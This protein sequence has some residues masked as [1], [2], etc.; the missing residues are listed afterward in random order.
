[1]G[2]TLTVELGLTPYLPLTELFDTNRQPIWDIFKQIQ[3]GSIIQIVRPQWDLR[4]VA[5]TYLDISHLG[6]A[7][8]QDD[9]ILFREASL[10]Q[11]KVADTPLVSYLQSLLNQPT[12]KGIN[13]QKFM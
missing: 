2:D 4:A 12:I 10:R 5:G 3:H 6:F 13:I 9:K 8:W 11:K 7:I 1:M